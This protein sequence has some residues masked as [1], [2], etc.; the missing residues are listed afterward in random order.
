MFQVSLFDYMLISTITFFT[1]F[2][3]SFKS[4]TLKKTHIAHA[5]GQRQ[6]KETNNTNKKSIYIKV[7]FSFKQSRFSDS[8]SPFHFHIKTLFFS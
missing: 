6:N 1:Q 2:T 3:I 5:P 8:N 7:M 4:V